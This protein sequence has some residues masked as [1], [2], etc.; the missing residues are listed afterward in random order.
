MKQEAN[1]YYG[2]YEE[3]GAVLKGYA[4]QHDIRLGAAFNGDPVDREDPQ[5]VLKELNKSVI[6]HSEIDITNDILAC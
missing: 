6:Y 1:I 5:E 3:I 2:C 4:E